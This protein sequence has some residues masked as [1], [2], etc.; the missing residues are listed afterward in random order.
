MLEEEWKKKKKI[1][2]NDIPWNIST[3]IE[4][5]N[6]IFSNNSPIFLVNTTV[7]GAYFLSIHFS[8][9]VLCS[10]LFAL[11]SPLFAL[12]SHT[13]FPLMDAKFGKT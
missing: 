13:N 5:L 7:I 1:E 2:W 3:V 4:Y 11:R 9:W 12:R 6:I 8:I 10:Q